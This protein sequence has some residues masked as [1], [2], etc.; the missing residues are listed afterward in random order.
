M[1]TQAPLYFIA[2]VAESPVQEEVTGLKRQVETQFGSRHAL[3]AP[4]HITLLPPFR[5]DA[6]KIG[7]VIDR[8]Q[9]ICVE[10]RPFSMVLD[11]IDTFDPRV[12][13][14]AVDQDHSLHALYRRLERNL[15]PIVT[16]GKKK[17]FQRPF[18]PHMTI[19]NR[20]LTEQ[21]F[22]QAREFFIDLEYQREV[23]VS[24]VTILRHDGRTWDEWRE[25]PLKS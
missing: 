17:Q 13:F 21:M 23:T 18:H 24:A 16:N 4:A 1:T 11:G 12:I 7:T 20:D 15:L 19:A 3:K 10:F 22:Y 14:I 6:Q 2:W 9:E 25:I 5:A 8:L